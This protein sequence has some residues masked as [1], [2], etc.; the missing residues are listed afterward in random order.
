[1]KLVI[2]CSLG[3]ANSTL[4]DLPNLLKTKL[5]LMGCSSP[6]TCSEVH[7]EPY[8]IHYKKNPMVKYGQTLLMGFIPCMSDLDIFSFILKL[9]FVLML[10]IYSKGKTRFWSASEKRSPDP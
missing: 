8:Y 6:T 1:M 9:V 2:R 5:G 7:G 4:S 10:I 3:E